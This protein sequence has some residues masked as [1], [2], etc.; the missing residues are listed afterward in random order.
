MN[1]FTVPLLVVALC[2]ACIL[3]LSSGPA[4]VSF[5]DVPGALVRSIS[6]DAEPTTAD[7][8]VSSIRAPRTLLGIVA[9]ACLATSGAVLQGLFRNP[10]VDP[11]LIGVAPGAAFAASAFIVLGKHVAGTARLVGL[12]IAA[13]LGALAAA[14]LAWRVGSRAGRL[15]VASLL[16][17]G[18][19]VTAL[20]SAGTGALT[21][22]ATDAELRDLTFWA[23]GSL[24][25]ATWTRVLAVVP[26]TLL[27]LGVLMRLG[28]SLDAVSLGEASAGHLGVDV[29]RVK[30]RAVVFTSLAVGACVALTGVISF[31][32]L[33]VPHL[34]RMLQ[35]PRHTALLPAAALLGALFLV[36][37]DV[38]ARNAIAP[39][40]VPLGIVLAAV[41]APFFLA[42]VARQRAGIVA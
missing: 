17:A 7:F 13:F 21:L 28:P 4:S 27:A 39:A 30:R 41:G 22:H 19:G 15:A 20:A 31:V 1:R 18:I 25:G 42:L 40:E 29:E 37:A 11:S 24:N 8:V 34:V 26:W 5:W 16:L 33:V 38:V 2:G 14:A 32:G 36:L 23:L 12:P 6:R 35:G 10:L 9:G 3:S